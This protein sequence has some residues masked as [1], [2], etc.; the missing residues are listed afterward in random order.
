MVDVDGKPLVV[1]IISPALPPVLATGTVTARSGLIFYIFRVGLRGFDLLQVH[2]GHLRIA[3]APSQCHLWT[4]SSLVV[5]ISR[6]AFPK[7][8]AANP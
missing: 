7:N 8:G 6:K 1:V 2:P 3:S 4:F 5:V